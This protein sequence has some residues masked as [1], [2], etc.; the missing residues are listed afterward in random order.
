[1]GQDHEWTEAPN[2]DGAAPEG[3]STLTRGSFLKRAGLGVL[4]AS[5]VPTLLEYGLPPL[6]SART[7]ATKLQKFA[8]IEQQFGTFFTDNFNKPATAYIKTKPGWSVTFG[9]ENNTVTTGINLLNQYDA[10]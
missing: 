5:A 4:G 10:A 1:M 2:E 6:A 3:A 9:N 7:A 8:V